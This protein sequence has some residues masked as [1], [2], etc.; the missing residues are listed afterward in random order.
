MAYLLAEP[1]VTLEPTVR[2]ARSGAG[3]EIERSLQVRRFG[4][5]AVVVEHHGQPPDDRVVRGD[6]PPARRCHAGREP[7]RHGRATVFDVT[8]DG[9]GD[10]TDE[11]LLAAV[12]SGS[13]LALKELYDRH[14]PWLVVRLRRRCADPT[15]VHDTVQDTFV[16]VWRSADRFNGSGPVAAWIWG[17]GVRRLVG[18]FRTAGKASTLPLFDGDTSSAADVRAATLV[19]AEELV[20]E[21]VEHGD[22]A[23]AINGLSPELRMVV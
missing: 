3:H 16:A 6:A 13:R 22:L 4:D 17:I 20:L 23:G 5:A 18:Q 14:A 10:A 21:Q 2:S 7:I 9:L 8:R 15:I 1:A 19:S 12:A 11:A